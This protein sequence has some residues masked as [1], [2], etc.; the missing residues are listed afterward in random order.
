[1]C[2]N[3]SVV[4]KFFVVSVYYLCVDG[5]CDG[6]LVFFD[7][8]STSPFQLRVFDKI[9]GLTRLTTTGGGLGHDR[10]GSSHRPRNF[11]LSFVL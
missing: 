9:E 2:V 4:V 3:L 5:L 8:V 7:F 11:R 1:M 10:T 6:D